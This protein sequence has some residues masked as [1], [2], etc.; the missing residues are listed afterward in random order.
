MKKINGYCGG[1]AIGFMI[2]T[3]WSLAMGLQGPAIAFAIL[4]LTLVQLSVALGGE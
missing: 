2:S 3:M 4:A 1:G